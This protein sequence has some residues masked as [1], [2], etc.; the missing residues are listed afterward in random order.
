[1]QRLATGAGWLRTLFIAATTAF[2]V[3]VSG[4]AQA[5]EAHSGAAKDAPKPMMSKPQLS[6][7]TPGGTADHSKFEILKKDF[8]SGPEVTEACLSC[9]TEAAKQVKKSNHWTWE[10]HHSK[11]GQKL[12]KKTVIN[13]F[14]G[15]VVSNEPRCTSCHAGYDWKDMNQPPPS[16]DAKVDC[17]VCHDTTGEYSKWPTGAGHPIYEPKV[18]KGKT[19][20]PPNLTKVARNVGMPQRQNCGSCHYHGGGGDNIKHGDLSTALNHPDKHTDVHMAADGANFACTNCHVTKAH[21]WAGSRYDV[22]AT[23]PEGTGKPGQRRDVATCESCHST[24]PH[25]NTSL[26]G[27]KLNGHTDKVACQTCHIPE[28]AKGG[29]ATKTYWDWSSADKTGKKGE[30][31][32]DYVQ[33]DGKHRHG[34]LKHKGIFKWGEN[35]KPHYAWFDGQVEY[36]TIDRT[37]DPSKTV[38]V[39]KIKGSYNDPKSRIWPFKRMEGRQAYDAVLNKLVYTQVWGPTTSTAFWTNFDWQKSITHAMKTAG[40]EYSGKYGFVDTYMYWPITH[41]V[42]PKEE[43]LVCSDCHSR[44]GRLAGLPGFYMPGRDSFKWM[45]ILAY[46]ALAGSIVGVILHGALRVMLNKRK[47]Q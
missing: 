21:K 25:D 2:F 3:I 11:T 36:T 20:M 31:I 44:N 29:V 28:F 8:K 23:D 32:K 16:E 26:K 1:M 41:M 34:Y 7:N 43:A 37:I 35:V 4:T 46:L 13:A 42:S 27:I 12:G 19:I 15:N 47:A 40:L 30:G 39:N 33:G 5:Q 14:C 22:H 10:Y 24:H 45:D 38:E 9:H 18:K 6:A 17:L